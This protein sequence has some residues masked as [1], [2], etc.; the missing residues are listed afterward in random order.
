M[1]ESGAE[2]PVFSRAEKAAAWDWLRKQALEENNHH[3]GVAIVE[4]QAYHDA[5]K[6]IADDRSHDARRL[7]F[8][9]VDALTHTERMTPPTDASERGR[10]GAGYDAGAASIPDSG[11]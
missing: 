9:A 7:K 5:L 6:E 3:A 10:N 4:W 8:I 1:S 11:E 2:R